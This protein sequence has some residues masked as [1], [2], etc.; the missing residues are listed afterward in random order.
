MNHRASSAQKNNGTGEVPNKH[1][2]DDTVTGIVIF[3]LFIAAAIIMPIWLIYDETFL[4]QVVRVRGVVL[5]AS[6]SSHP[7]SNPDGTGGLA[8]NCDEQISFRPAG[9][10][11]VTFY[12][13]FPTNGLPFLTAPC[14][15]D[16]DLVTVLYNPRNPAQVRL[17]TAFY[18]ELHLNITL[19]ILCGAPLQLF[20]LGCLLHWC[21]RR[22]KTAEF[23][24]PE[25]YRSPDKSLPR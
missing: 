20:L 7:Y 3:G 17:S 2:S 4:V 25:P 24:Y 18:S 13:S 23:G 6:L 9:G 15:H 14:N 8:Y 11:P 19:E 21:R 22:K 1:T 10:Q 12:D 5:A 16:G